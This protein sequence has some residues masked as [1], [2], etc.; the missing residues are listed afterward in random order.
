MAAA[1]VCSEFRRRALR[2]D[3]EERGTPRHADV[4]CRS[5]MPAG[6]EGV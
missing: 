1:V 5:T 2:S 6:E 4:T 3:A